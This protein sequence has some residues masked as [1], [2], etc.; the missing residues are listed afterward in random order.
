MKKIYFL[1]IFIVVGIAV[2]FKIIAGNGNSK[3]GSDSD[4]KMKVNQ[5]IANTGGLRFVEN[6]GQ[7]MDMQRK[8]VRNVL[9]KAG[10]G[11]MDV[12]IT[13]TGLS[14][15]F[16]EINKHSKTGTA[17]RPNQS[18]HHLDDSLT[19]QYCRADMQLA[20]AN[21]RKEN[22]V[23]EDES[24]NRT[25][26]YYGD[27]CPNGIL[28]VRSYGKVTIKNIYPGIDWVLHSGKQGLKYDFIVHPGAN[29]SLIRLKYKWTDKPQLQDDGSV[30]IS[31]PMGNITEGTPVSY[32]GNEQHKI[33]TTYSVNNSEIHFKISNYKNAETLVIDPVLVWATY[34]GGGETWS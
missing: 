6:K 9:F 28:N 2:P 24:G 8:A 18:L 27:V 26:Y 17:A 1:F 3:V 20:G 33:Q 11:G 23:K 4:L 10:A 13:T 19:L 29:P 32:N 12:Y 16:T 15:V 34:Y 22:I 31:T 5:W 14:Y 21:I 25:D 7:M 30:K